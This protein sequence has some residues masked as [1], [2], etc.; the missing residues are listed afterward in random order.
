M[1]FS[2]ARRTWKSFSS[3]LSMFSFQNV[4][5]VCMGPPSRDPLMTSFLYRSKLL[6]PRMPALSFSSRN[7]SISMISSSPHVCVR[8]EDKSVQ[9]TGHER[10]QTKRQA[11]KPHASGA[12]CTSCNFDVQV[13]RAPASGE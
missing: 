9:V 12:E 3:N 2:S 7:D 4:S 8:R 10:L 6:I 11:G 13:R 1:S 5:L